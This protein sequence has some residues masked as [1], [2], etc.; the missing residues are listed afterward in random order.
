MTR[1]ATR[2]K[3][4]RQPNRPAN[5]KAND[6]GMF[7]GIVLIGIFVALL[8]MFS[9][10][11]NIT[12]FVYVYAA[13]VIALINLSVWQMV[14]RGRVAPIQKPLARLPLRFV[15][16][17]L[18]KTRP[19]EAAKGEPVARQAAIITSVISVI[20]IIGAGLWIFRTPEL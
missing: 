19:L 15:G 7:G 3:S 20:V 16:F 12:K 11:G 9:G 18:P 13:I 10:P 6:V 14:L 5:P 17:G 4:K 8:G 1:T 2:S